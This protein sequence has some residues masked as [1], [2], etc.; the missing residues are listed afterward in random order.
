M[1]TFTLE[2]LLA[3]TPDEFKP[4][5]AEYGPALVKM[6]ADEFAAWIKLLIDGKTPAAWAAI[7]AK[8]DGGAAVVD[9]WQS[10]DT[11]WAKENDAN[12]ARIELQK[13]AAMA[14]LKILLGIVLAAV[15]L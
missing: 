3:K 6:T 15:G 7:M 5:V 13:A 8:L 14:V 1:M 2:D 4:L 9:T 11:A 10:L 12:K